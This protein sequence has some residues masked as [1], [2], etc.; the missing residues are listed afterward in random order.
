MNRL[1][2][3]N[4]HIMVT[5]GEYNLILAGMKRAKA[6]NM[7]EYLSYLLI[8]GYVVGR[9]SS[10]LDKL[11]YEVNKVGTNINQ[12]V[13]LCN[14]NGRI[15]ETQVKDLSDKLGLIYKIMRDFEKA[16]T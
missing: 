15:G 4:I 2:D 12:A 14:I 1:R 5:E 3:R 10:G 11:S 8:N 13:H 16:L 7:R 9:D 6:S